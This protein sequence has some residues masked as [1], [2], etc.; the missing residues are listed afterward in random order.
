MPEKIYTVRLYLTEDSLPW[1]YVVKA[2]S[3]AHAETIVI[4]NEPR[5]RAHEY[6]QIVADEWDG[7]PYS[8]THDYL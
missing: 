8:F 2:I 1:C 7:R 6:Y 3:P 4:L 5:I